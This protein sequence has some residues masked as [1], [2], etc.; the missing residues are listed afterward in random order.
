MRDLSRG[1]L[2]PLCASNMQCRHRITLMRTLMRVQNVVGS[3]DVFVTS[4]WFNMS[5][6]I[7]YH[8]AM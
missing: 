5:D 8:V 3:K 2:L 7:T 1:D 6:K 4:A